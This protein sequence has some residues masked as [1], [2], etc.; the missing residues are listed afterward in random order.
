LQSSLKSF[1]KSPFQSVKHSN[2]FDVYDLLFKDLIGKEI[3]FVEIGI[4]DGGSLFMW[5]DFFG[6][7]AKIIGID[8]NPEAKK[9]ENYGFDIYIG[10]QS[11]ENFWKSTL[12]KIGNINVLLDDGGHTY[13]QQRVTVESALKNIVDGGLLVVEDTHTSY[14]KDFGGPSFFSFISYAKNKI[15]KSNYRFSLFINNK[16]YEKNIYSISFYESFVVFNINRKLCSNKSKL[17]TNLGEKIVAKDFR[18]KSSR[19]LTYINEKLYLIKHHKLNEDINLITKIYYKFIRTILKIVLKVS[20][21]IRRL[22]FSL[23]H[24][25]YFF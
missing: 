20:G 21:I 22:N 10:D 1:K 12:D 15:D 25:N 17:V 9:W 6:K 5:Q 7:N 3:V 4:L 24:I 13:E 23:R 16:D 18:D 8:F 14:M 11:D 2:Y 19:L